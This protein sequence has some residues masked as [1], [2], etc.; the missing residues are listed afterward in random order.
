HDPAAAL[1]GGVDGHE[2]VDRLI[3]GAAHWLAPGGALVVEIDDRRGLQACERACAAGLEQVRVAR[4]LAGRDRVL[5]AR[6]P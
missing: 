5:L 6:A 4:D 2:V 1:F 3:D